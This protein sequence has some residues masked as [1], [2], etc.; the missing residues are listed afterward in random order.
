MHKI[1]FASS[2]VQPL[3]KTGGLADVSGALPI[4]LKALKCDVRIIMPAYSEATKTTKRLKTV[5]EFYLPGIA[6]KILIKERKLPQSSIKVLFVDYPAAFARMG[7]P[8]T[9]DNGKSWPDNAERFALF[10]RAIVEVAQNRIDLQWQPDIVHCNDW[11]TGLVPAL[12]SLETI[13]PATVFTIHNLAYQGIFDMDAF[14][15]LGLPDQLWSYDA[16]EFHNQLSFIKGGLVF[17]DQITTVSPRYAKEI[18]TSE[19][20]NGLE[21]L[22]KFKQSMLTGILNGIDMDTWDPASDV[23]IAKN[24]DISHI[25]NKAINKTAL[26]EQFG[27][28][29]DKSILLIGAIPN[30]KV[31]T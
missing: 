26:Q 10:C 30:K 29:I 17:S 8:Y 15:H 28:S 20:G 1:L 31:S 24:F 25:E 14:R 18:Q 27:L 4:A 23:H 13:R 19:F 5:G 9:M 7:N 3:I 2:E 6:G 16:L 21:D 11:Q 22:L 12:L